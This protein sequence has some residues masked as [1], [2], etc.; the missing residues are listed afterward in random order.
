M[1]SYY[2]SRFIYQIPETLT[3]KK[4]YIYHTPVTIKQYEENSHH[5]DFSFQ[6][7]P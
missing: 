4:I 6:D 2:D 5:F 3:T 7:C 1:I